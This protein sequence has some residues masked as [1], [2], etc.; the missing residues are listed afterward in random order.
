MPAA[1]AHQ[2]VLAEGCLSLA[3]VGSTVLRLMLGVDALGV[4]GM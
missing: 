3:Q 4:L 1:A 2:A